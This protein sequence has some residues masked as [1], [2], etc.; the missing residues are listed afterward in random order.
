M[1]AIAIYWIIGS[2]VF[3]NLGKWAEHLLKI[4]NN[5]LFFT[6]ING[7]FVFLIYFSLAALFTGVYGFGLHLAFIVLIIYSIWK[8]M[9]FSYEKISCWIRTEKKNIYLLTGLTVFFL[10]LSS[11][12]PYLSV[13]ET[14]YIQTIK[15]AGEYGITKGLINLHPFLGQFSTWHILQAAF[16]PGFFIFN[17]IN[18]L[19]LLMYLFYLLFKANKIRKKDYFTFEERLLYLYLIFFPGLLLFINSPSPDLPVIIL[20]QM[21]FYLYFRNFYHIKRDEFIQL[22]IFVLFAAAV[23][24]TALPLLFLPII[25]LVKYKKIVPQSAFYYYFL[26]IILL[27]IYLAYKNYIISGYPF[28]PFSFFGDKIQADWKYP[29]EILKNYINT[30]KSNLYGEEFSR[31][32][33]KNFNNWIF[34]KDFVVFIMNFIWIVTLLLLPFFIRKHS[35][36]KALIPIYIISLIYFFILLFHAP[37]I[38][39]FLYFEILFFVLIWEKLLFRF[40]AGKIINGSILVIFLIGF[41]L[42]V[43]HSRSLQMIYNPMALSKYNNYETQLRNI[44]ILNYPVEDELF[45]ETG[46]ACLPAA[47]PKMLDSLLKHNGEKYNL[48]QREG[49]LQSGF[50]LEKEH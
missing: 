44:F 5:P 50:K 46:E 40:P 38:S 9:E 20:S 31:C 4:R 3:I 48:M 36:K 11:Q 12:I 8:N 34:H 47:Q 35:H 33:L 18:G 49:N 10:L 29:A 39:Y 16:N 7:L 45:W 17:D 13:N 22:V 37:Y 23:K 15:W 21:A 14:Y 27:L 1:I 6:F 42:F 32:P 26:S 24:T 25:L 41:S 28:F 30:N 43:T 19:L 2:F